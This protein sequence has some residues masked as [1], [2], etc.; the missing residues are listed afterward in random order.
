LSKSNSAS[1][2]TLR[3]RSQRLTATDF[4]A[5][6]PFGTWMSPGTC[7]LPFGCLISPGTCHFPVGWRI[8]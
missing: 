5:W 7:H 3:R 2:T 4:T 8:S 1:A 6:M